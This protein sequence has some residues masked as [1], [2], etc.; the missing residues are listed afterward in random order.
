M[1][2]KNNMKRKQTLSQQAEL[3]ILTRSKF[4]MNFT[5][6]LKIL[7]KKKSFFF[8]LVMNNVSERDHNLKILL[9]LFFGVYLNFLGV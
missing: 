8:C 5:S 9:F 4:I 2:T 6:F 3:I 1:N 7:L